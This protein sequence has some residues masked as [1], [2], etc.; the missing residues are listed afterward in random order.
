MLLGAKLNSVPECSK[1]VTVSIASVEMIVSNKRVTI[2]H[3]LKSDMAPG[4]Q[5]LGCHCCWNRSC[6]LWDYKVWKLAMLGL[7]YWSKGCWTIWH[8]TISTGPHL[9]NWLGRCLAPWFMML[10][11]TTANLNNA[12]IIPHN[13]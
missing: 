10:E 2:M 13:Y 6:L 11:W 4:F 1:M 7:S 8:Y 3:R 9:N 5:R 12:W